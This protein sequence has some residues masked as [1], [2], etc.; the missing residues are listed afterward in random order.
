MEGFV[1]ELAFIWFFRGGLGSKMVATK[2]V[3]MCESREP[4]HITLYVKK[5]D[6]VKDFERRLPWIIKVGPVQSNYNILIRMRQ[7]KI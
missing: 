7:R 1:W 2:D 3:S 5:C 4:L 6:E